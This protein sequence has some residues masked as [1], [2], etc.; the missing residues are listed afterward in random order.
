MNATSLTQ[1]SVANLLRLYSEILA[2]L[3]QR[4]IVR[5][6]NNPVADY[7]E[8]L[9]VKAL[10]LQRAP[11]STKGYDAIDEKGHKYEIKGRRPTSSNESRMLSA[12]RNCEAAH[13]DYLAG[14]LFNEDFSFDKACVVPF[15]IVLAEAK[16]RKH[17]NAHIFELRDSLWGREGVL[18]IS[19]DVRRVITSDAAQ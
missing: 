18:D 3:K 12:I 13:F 15:A 16:Y 9:V 8:Y 5:S 19:D 17:V 14:I 1:M 2:E 10:R 4:G 6:T 7:A 11:K